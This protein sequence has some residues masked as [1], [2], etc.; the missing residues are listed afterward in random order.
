[1]ESL[2]MFKNLYL[3][4][5]NSSKVLSIELDDAEVDCLRVKIVYIL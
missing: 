2:L 4:S 1:M 5:H 3:D